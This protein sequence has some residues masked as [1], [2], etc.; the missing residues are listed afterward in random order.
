MHIYIVYSIDQSHI[1]LPTL[2]SCLP[3][4]WTSWKSWRNE[5]FPQKYKRWKSGGETS[6]MLKKEESFSMCLRW[7][8]EFLHCLFRA[9]WV[10]QFLLSYIYIYIC[11]HIHIKYILHPVSNI[12]IANISCMIS[13]SWYIYVVFLL[14]EVNYVSSYHSLNLEIP[15]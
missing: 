5:H 15:F 6:K 3:K 1:S 11:I 8:S 4:I 13:S 10:P 2:F 7:I 12:Y 14:Q 9:F